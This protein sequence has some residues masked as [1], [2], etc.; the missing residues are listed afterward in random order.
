MNSPQ[1]LNDPHPLLTTT[2]GRQ[3]LL[4]MALNLTRNTRLAPSA[5]EQQLL[6]LFVQGTLT[7]DQV[8]EQLPR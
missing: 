5:Q 1:A 6:T 2:H 8:L 3:R 4:D 7:L